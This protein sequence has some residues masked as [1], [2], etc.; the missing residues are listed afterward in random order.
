MI[1]L[2][3]TDPIEKANSILSVRCLNGLR[4]SGLFTIGDLM[5]YNREDLWGIKNLGKQSVSEIISFIETFIETL[6]SGAGEFQLVSSDELANYMDDEN[7]EKDDNE[8]GELSVQFRDENGV[9]RDDIPLEALNLS[10]RSYHRLIGSGYNF[11]SQLI[12]VTEKQLLEI[13][14]LGRDSVAEIIRKIKSLNF[15]TSLTNQSSANTNIL[16]KTFVSNISSLLTIHGDTLYQEL[17]PIFER[18]EEGNIVD[19]K[20]LFAIVDLRNAV[21]D[22]IFSFLN[23]FKFGTDI[24]E[25]MSLLP[26]NIIE[27]GIMEEIIIEM[28]SEG[29]ILIGDK[30]ECRRITILEYVQNV[31][32][33]DEKNQWEIFLNRLQGLTLEE[34]GSNYKITRERVRQIVARKLRYLRQTV[35]LA[36]DKYI[37]VFTNYDFTQEKFADIFG[38]NEIVYNY[39]NLICDKKSSIAQSLEQFIEDETI[40]IELRA[41]AE[42]VIEK[43]IAKKNVIIGEEKIYKSRAEIFDYIVRTYFHDEGSFDEFIEVY[44]MVLEDFGLVGDKNLIIDGRSYENRLIDSDKILWK[45]GR[46]FRY[47]DIENRDFT[48]FIQELALNQYHD[49]EYSTLKFFRE[50]S[51]LMARYDVR[52]EYELHNLLKKIYPKLK[53]ENI[54]FGRM[55]IVEFGK[56]DR[57]IQVLDM[58]IKLSPVTLQDFGVAY[59]TEY[60]VQSTTVMANFM[61]NFDEYFHEGIY[62]VPPLLFN[63]RQLIYNVAPD[64]LTIELLIKILAER[65]INGFRIDSSIEL[66]RLRRFIA[67][68]LENEFSLSDEE[69]TR[70]ILSC[71]ILF[72]GKVYIVSAESKNQITKTVEDYLNSGAKIIFYEEFYVKNEYGLFEK[73]IV[74]EKMLNNIFRQLFPTLTFTQTYFGYMNVSVYHAVES[75]I[76]RVWSDDL[77]LNYEQIAERLRYIPLE[78]IKFTLGQNNDFIW[79]NIGTFSHIGKVDITEDERTAICEMVQRECNIHRYASFANLPLNEIIERNHDLS[80]TAI[81]TAIYRMC[82]SEGYNKQGKILTQKGEITDALIIMKEYCRILDKCTLDELFDF[83]KDLTGEIH[84]WIPMQA[85]YDIMVRTDENIFLAE[86]YF[87]FDAAAVDNAIE[88]F[89][90]GEY[91]PLR[92]ITTFVM[93]PH[94][95]QPWNLFLLESYVRRFS[96]KF[97]FETPSVNNQNVGCIVRK[98]SKLTYGD[99]MADA[100]ASSNI[101]INENTVANFLYENGYRGNRQKAKIADIIQQA[102]NLRERMD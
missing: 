15:T 76:L 40:P 83:E 27:R 17:L 26:N 31:I 1:N 71:G 86:K 89:G 21:K 77:L 75:E 29:K 93:F 79:N 87:D 100:V 30:I 70:L 65:Y 32:P 56:A 23:D 82:L 52:D 41:N 7:N 55:P 58:L 49:V 38:E 47:Y 84:R 97:R 35:I 10:K 73:S 42:K 102:K 20:E 50:H 34:I 43:R 12:G 85:G 53:I 22:R 6:K 5:N 14:Q 92:L 25:V 36:E 39:M 33:K 3:P 98:Y 45:R 48:E 63:K 2:M 54:N 94:C 24:S 16:C 66:S 9:L 101:Q 51:S 81:H 62:N 8:I 67:D 37:D 44:N 61:K 96:D 68:D 13:K 95:G 11:A 99:I 64:P 18:A 74:S 88:Y 80:I 90:Q 91:I 72:D 19:S 57:D 69:L 28:K 59:E 60:G 4:R 78:R 46:R